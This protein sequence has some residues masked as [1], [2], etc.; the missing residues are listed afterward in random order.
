MRKILMIGIAT[1]G[2]A[3][4][5]PALADCEGELMEAD[6]ELDAAVI[7]E[8]ERAEAAALL[9]EA[10]VALAAGDEA[11]C[12]EL[13]MQAR[14]TAGLEREPDGEPDADDADGEAEADAEDGDDNGEAE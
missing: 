8:A 1:I 6:A 2:L 7:T 14:T 9:A 10:E 13:V 3:L 4:A 11:A 12:L 5:G